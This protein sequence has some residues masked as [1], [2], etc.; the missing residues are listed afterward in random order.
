MQDYASRLKIPVS[1][2]PTQEFYAVTGTLVAVGYLR[3]CIGGRGPY[4]EFKRDNFPEGLL[5]KQLRPH[6]Y[7]NE[8]RTIPDHLFVYHQLKPVNYADYRPGLFY[9]SPFDLY[10]PKDTLVIAPIIGQ[11][12]ITLEQ[13]PLPLKPR[14]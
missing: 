11:R 10:S 2:N 8:Y 5:Q 14:S 13:I 12:R 6:Y 4:I 9:I 3:V 7:F 1:G